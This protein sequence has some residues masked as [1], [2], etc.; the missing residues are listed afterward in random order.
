[1]NCVI[2][3]LERNWFLSP[4][5]GQ[6]MPPVEVDLWER[7]YI[8]A[9]GTFGYC[10]GIAWYQDFW[11]YTVVCDNET[12]HATKYQI[13]GTGQAQSPS[14]EK[15]A[16]GLGDRVILPCITHGTKQRLVLGIELVNNSWC[17]AVEM[18]SPTLSRTLTTPNRFTSVNEQDLIRVLL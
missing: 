2:S 4:P 15:P 12:F 14:V 16:F 1:M 7:A 11:L 8:T 3:D 10:C 6:Q 9:T 17:Y 5:W 13:I 18:I